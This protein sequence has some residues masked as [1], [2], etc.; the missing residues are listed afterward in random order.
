[1]AIVFYPFTDIILCTHK[2]KQKSPFFKNPRMKTISTTHTSTSRTNLTP[3]LPPLGT[4]CGLVCQNPGHPPGR[5]IIVDKSLQDHGPRG[6]VYSA[7]DT[8]P[9]KEVDSCGPVNEENCRKGKKNKKRKFSSPTVWT[10]PS[11]PIKM[12]RRFQKQK[13]GLCGV[14]SINNALGMKLLVREEV[15]L[16]VKKL[17]R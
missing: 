10:A 8:H 2:S 16:M 7:S 6:G 14:I 15:D 9:A 1:M 3:K 11:K 4:Q 12:K 5:P 13:Q 17:Q